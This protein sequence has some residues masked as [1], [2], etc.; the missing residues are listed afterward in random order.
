MTPLFT[1]PFLRGYQGSTI[2]DLIV[3]A[4]HAAEKGETH[5]A[6]QGAVADYVTKPDKLK[7][8]TRALS[9]ARDAAF[10]HDDTKIAE[11]NALAAT[12]IRA[13]DHNSYHIILLADFHKD[14]SILHNAG[15]EPRPPKTSKVKSVP[16]QNL[17]V[18]FG[19]G[20]LPSVWYSATLITS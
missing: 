18:P 12:L 8:I 2:N 13:L 1:D 7:E 14:P 3:F 6:F 5:V 20:S 17:W 9:M 11:Q 4:N 10:G 15:Y 16:Q 19:S